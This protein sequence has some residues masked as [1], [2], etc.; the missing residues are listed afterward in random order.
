MIIKSP[1]T[2]DLKIKKLEDLQK[3]KPFMEEQI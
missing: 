1:I 2:T 3:L